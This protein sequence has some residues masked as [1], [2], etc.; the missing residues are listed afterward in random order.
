M[1]KLREELLLLR[2]EECSLRVL[3]DLRAVVWMVGEWHAP[4]LQEAGRDFG[5]GAIERQPGEQSH[6]SVGVSPGGEKSPGDHGETAARSRCNS[7]TQHVRLHECLVPQRLLFCRHAGPASRR[8]YRALPCDFQSR[9]GGGP[10]PRSPCRGGFERIPISKMYFL[11]TLVVILG[12]C[13][14]FRPNE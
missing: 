4:R 10:P 6:V 3:L 7:T 2:S 8:R 12:P 1:R 5:P 13:D 11:S 9:R 14:T